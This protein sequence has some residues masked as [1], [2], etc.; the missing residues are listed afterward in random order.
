MALFDEDAAK[1]DADYLSNLAS[2]YFGMLRPVLYFHIDR[3][4]TVI[5]DLYNE[6]AI[7]EE[8]QFKVEIEVN[9]YLDFKSKEN[10]Q[11]KHGM[12]SYRL[13]IFSIARIDL[14]RHNI[15]P[16]IGDRIDYNGELFEVTD[17][18]QKSYYRGIID[19][20]NHWSLECKIVRGGEV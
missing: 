16:Q 18:Q 15:S 1:L 13:P 14:D 9:A 3:E 7:G 10:E 12:D 8:T 6:V 4:A 2:G 20:F 5:D 19:Y 11:V 17:P